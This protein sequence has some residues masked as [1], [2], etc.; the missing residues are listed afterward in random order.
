MSSTNYHCYF[1]FLISGSAL[2]V[3]VTI[4]RCITVF[5]WMMLV[6]SSNVLGKTISQ[7]IIK[8]QKVSII[9][10]DKN[11]KVSCI[12]ASRSVPTISLTILNIRDK[13]SNVEKIIAA[14]ITLNVINDSFWAW[15][16]KITKFVCI[17]YS[18]GNDIFL[19]FIFLI[20]ICFFVF[21]RFFSKVFVIT[22]FTVL[23]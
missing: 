18:R 20:R 6:V 8:Y 4:Q 21:I 15:T 3:E 22:T 11:V 13:K 12:P 19:F 1:W 9:Y 5:N 14:Q 7:Y 10:L 2:F 16:Q 17:D 23:I